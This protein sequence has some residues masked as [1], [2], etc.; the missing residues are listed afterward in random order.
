VTLDLTENRTLNLFDGLPPDVLAAAAL[1]LAPPKPV[2]DAEEL[3]TLGGFV[4]AAQLRPEGTRPFNLNEIKYQ[5]PLYA[6]RRDDWLP[7]VVIQKAAQTGL[8]IRLLNRA[9]W[10]CAD[11]LE[12]VNSAL[13]FPT[14]DAVQELNVS[15]FRPMLRS[16]ARMLELL[17]GNIDRADLARIGISN[18]RFRGMRSGVSVDSFPADYLGFD[19]V[20]LMS[21]QMIERAF[22]RISASTKIH[23]RTGHRGIIDLNSTAGFPDMDINR[24]FERHST[25][26][27][28]ASQCPDPGCEKHKS[29]IV[30]PLEFAENLKRVIGQDRNG[31]FYYRCPRCGAYLS[32]D[33][34]QTG[35][36]N[37][38]NPKAEWQ[39]FQFS[40]LLKGEDWLNS[41]LMPAYLRADNMPE[42]YN[43]RLGLP[44]EDR[45]AVIGSQA[46]VEACMDLNYTFP[47]E[48]LG[49]NAEWRVMGLDQGDTQQHLVIKTLM[50]DGRHRLDHI[51]V[52]EASD[53]KAAAQILQTFVRWGCKLLLMDVRP[54]YHFFRMVSQELPAGVAYAAYYVDGQNADMV[55]WLDNRDKAATQKADGEVKTPFSAPIQRTQALKWSLNLFRFGRQ[56]LPTRQS[57]HSLI[58]SRVTAGVSRPVVIGEEF[59]THMGN[60]AL[61]KENRQ[62]HLPTGE[63]VDVP[64]EYVERFRNLRMDPHFVHANLYADLALARMSGSTQ[65]HSLTAAA[66]VIK[67]QIDAAL[68]EA[69]R[70]STIAAE[71][72]KAKS[73]TCGGCKYF[74]P[75][76]C[77]HPQEL[78]R[79]VRTGE[80]TPACELYR[81]IRAPKPTLLEQ[82]APLLE[83]NQE[84][85]LNGKAYRLHDHEQEA[86]Y[87]LPEK[88]ED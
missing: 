53:L 3:S 22:V 13:M 49:R 4:E 75:P 62:Q 71:Q 15:R 66:P 80:D 88:N 18:M 8:T 83:G 54:A 21:I 43:A 77:G 7:R 19:E 76:Y 57:F 86:P 34:T 44:F 55:R 29:G 45:N 2:F 69:L 72:A 10:W 46:V 81:R 20:R 25:Q 79:T 11:A 60:I 41:E 16:S 59:I 30:L 39:G 56:L 52:I 1:I 5:I 85:T 38:L 40:Q 64:G 47:A 73:R 51:E 28:W 78:P 12:Q 9:M 42:F 14:R 6:E 61:I 17:R 26:G 65:L 24:W 36:Y 48:P 23:P 31:R 63:R 87:R 68:P 82:V 58:Q 50:P 74:A 33:Q 37:H 27:Y 70:P 84:V 35:W 67:T 32:D